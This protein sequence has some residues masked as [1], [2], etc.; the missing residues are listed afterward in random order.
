MTI[1]YEYHKSLYVN[2][3]NRCS[4]ACSFCVRNKHDNVNGEDNLWLDREPTVEEIKQDFEKRDMSKY[5]QVVFCGYGEPMERFDDL[6]EVSRWIKQT[7][8]DMPIRINTNGQA[9]LICGR[10]VTPD[11]KGVIDVVSISLNAPNAK[12]YQELCKSRYGEQAFEALQEFAK[13]ANRYVDRVVF[14][15]VDKTMPDED[16]EECRKIAQNCG[17]EF[18]V[19]A[20][21]D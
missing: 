10:D 19:R 8:P 18:R 13:L 2:I 9:N 17:V 15:V 14:S 7:C 5:D 6:I 3:T 20:Y 21:I 16:I 11:M 4:N 1:T 12:E